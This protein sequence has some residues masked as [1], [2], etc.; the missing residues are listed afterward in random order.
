MISTYARGLIY[1]CIINLA[2]VFAE[3][4]NAR[5]STQQELLMATPNLRSF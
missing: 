2:L 3:R 4:S 1:A 5:I